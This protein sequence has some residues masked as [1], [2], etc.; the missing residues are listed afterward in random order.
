MALVQPDWTPDDQ[1]LRT[2]GWTG[3]VGF[4]V[5]GASIWW[6]EA[7]LFVELGDASTGLGIASVAAGLLCALG[8]WLRPGALRLVYVGLV[9][10][11]LPIG[12]VSS[13]LLIAVIY[14]GLVTPIGLA[15]RLLGRDPLK[16][17]LDREA[18]TYWEP[19]E[20]HDDKSR[21]LR[22]F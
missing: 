6:R 7:F 20:S 17:R 8:A 3:L 4:S 12:F 10:A 9:A 14:L 21:Y 1:K 15:M 13:H 2:F 18:D 19:R 16:L 11:T 22:Q 5:L